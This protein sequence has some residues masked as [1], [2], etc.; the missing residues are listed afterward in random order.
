VKI[1]FFLMETS[2]RSA[3]R[4]SGPIDKIEYLW[5]GLRRFVF[6]AAS[7]DNVLGGTT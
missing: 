7:L 3:I 1:V 2:K 6:E 4:Q 5:E